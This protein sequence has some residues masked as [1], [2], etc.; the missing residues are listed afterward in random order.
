MINLALFEPITAE[1]LK[2]LQPGEWIWDNADVYRGEHKLTLNPYAVREPKGFR[3]IHI[4][5]LKDFPSFSSKPFML[6]SVVGMYDKGGYVW[7]YFEENRFYRLKE[8]THD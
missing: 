5:D 4:M 6:S 7:T 2:D 8:K 1:T 3:Q